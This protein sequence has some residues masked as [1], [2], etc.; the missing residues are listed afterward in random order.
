MRLCDVAPGGASLLVSRGLLNLTHRGGHAERRGRPAR[1]RM[2]VRIPLDA[3]G[4]AFLPGHRIRIAVSSTYWPFA[5][6]SPEPVTL[7][8]HVGA[9]TRLEL[10]VRAPS[11]ADDPQPSFEEPVE[12]RPEE[13]EAGATKERRI[14]RDLGTGRAV[15]ELEA[16]EHVRFA[17]DDLSHREHWLERYTIVDGDPL[18]ALITRTSSQ[19]LERGDWRIAVHTEASLSATPEDFLVTSA[20]DAFEA[21]VR[22]F[23]RRRSVRIPR[24]GV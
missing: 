5:W 2:A 6:P 9:G 7:T 21:D 3:A 12:A 10:P 24:D 8:V 1:E 15:L 22:V 19:R 4:H 13:T 16:T 20:I 14:V 18:S 11:P 17:G 23:T